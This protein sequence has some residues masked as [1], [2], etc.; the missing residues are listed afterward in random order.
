MHFYKMSLTVL[1]LAYICAWRGIAVPSKVTKAQIEEVLGTITQN[2]RQ[3]VE[4]WY[5]RSEGNVLEA[6]FCHD[7]TLPPTNVIGRALAMRSGV[8]C[9]IPTGMLNSRSGQEE[10]TGQRLMIAYYC[11]RGLPSTPLKEGL[12]DEQKRISIYGEI[13]RDKPPKT[14]LVRAGPGTG[15][16]ST[17]IEMARVAVQ[18]GHT[19]LFLAYTNS[20]VTTLKRRVSADPYLGSKYRAEPFATKNAAVSSKRSI[21]L[22]TVDQM[23]RAV[24]TGSTGRSVNTDLGFDAIVR[25]A[26]IMIQ[27]SKH[28]LNIFLESPIVPKF[29]HIIVDEAQMLSDDRAAFIRAVANGLS[30]VGIN[31]MR[32]CHL[33][34][35]CDPKQT[36]TPGAGQ[37][38]VSLY[39]RAARTTATTGTAATSSVIEFDGRTWELCDL[40][41][42]FR[43]AT[44]EMLD[45]VM[46][47]SKARPALHVDLIAGNALVPTKGPAAYAR[48][49]LDIKKVAEE[50]QSFYKITSSV[51][52]LTPTLGRTNKTSAQIASLVL[53]LQ[54]LNVPI[55]V[56]GDGN[57]QGN[58][59]VITTFNSCAG[60]EFNHVFIFGASGYPKN[61]L[62]IPAE[63][64]RSLMFVA[65]S[66]AKYSICYVLNKSELCVDVDVRRVVPFFNTQVIEYELPTMYDAK[67]PKCWTS[68]VL[69]RDDTG[70]TFMTCNG[71]TIVKHCKQT[72]RDT[73]ATCPLYEALYVLDEAHRMPVL[74]DA[75]RAPKKGW[76]VTPLA[77]HLRGMATRGRLVCLDNG[78]RISDDQGR[79]YIMESPDANAGGNPSTSQ[80]PSQ[81]SV[82]YSSR[83]LFYWYS[84]MRIEPTIERAAERADKLRNLLD[85]CVTQLAS[86]VAQS[87]AAVTIKLCQH[88]ARK[89]GT[90]TDSTNYMIYAPDAMFTV[91]GR[92][93]YI[94]YTE[95]AYVAMYNATLL[96]SPESRPWAIQV[97]PATGTIKVFDGFHAKMNYLLDALKRTHIFHISTIFRANF[98]NVPPEYRPST[99]TYA[100]DTEFN[101]G[102]E[103]Y[104]IGLVCLSDPFRSMCSLIKCPSIQGWI[105]KRAGIDLADYQEI[106]VSESDF[107]LD[108]VE[109][110]TQL[111]L[112]HR[113]KII[114]FVSSVDVAWAQDTGA[115]FIELASRLKQRIVTSGTFETDSKTPDLDALYGSYVGPF[116]ITNRH[117][118]FPD[119]VALGEICNAAWSHMFRN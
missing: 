54:R 22:S 75:E 117:R 59:V 81:A 103:I 64:G 19:V 113:P 97:S 46:H 66:R 57:Y 56:H 60:M 51:G 3:A 74:I 50:I 99:N 23:A 87:G 16:T 31:G 106:A 2:E 27:N 92:A 52:V 101:N 36:I 30:I 33:T 77:A 71:L 78:R 107:A 20:A 26:L 61:N 48:C 10:G 116:E 67:L 37:W 45:F 12:T 114:H 73:N 11:M 86:D 28:A 38:L 105:L 1:S 53:E 79:P 70:S 5:R 47:I 21:L 25:N 58:G 104:E 94:T 40:T 76:T 84:N 69:F 68:D 95:N 108:F 119:A 55:C 49:V 80:D 109:C 102:S 118:A 96:S 110:A 9:L 82:P 83:D 89:T 29:D 18:A 34:V 35:F 111:S 85:T 63:T 112:Q 88:G 17:G 100:V 39:E 7:G 6:W 90:S 43:F 32:S 13:G 93:G 4:Q 24:L 115:Q 41:R 44:A 98:L 8:Q 15:K 91:G 72:I 14:T 62:Q 42:T 65:N